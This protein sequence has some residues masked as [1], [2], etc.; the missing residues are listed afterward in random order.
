MNILYMEGGGGDIF[1]N[2][3]HLIGQWE[4][5]ENIIILFLRNVGFKFEN[6]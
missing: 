5:G 1:I 6:I 2:I 3:R 4:T